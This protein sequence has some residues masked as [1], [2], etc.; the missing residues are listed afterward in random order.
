M[1]ELSKGADRDVPIGEEGETH[2]RANS[3]ILK[4]NSGKNPR[5]FKLCVGTTSAIPA[6]LQSYLPKKLTLLKTRPLSSSC[7]QN[8]VK[9][10]PNN[11][12]PTEAGSGTTA[13][14]RKKVSGYQR[15]GVD[16]RILSLVVHPIS[17]PVVRTPTADRRA[18]GSGSLDAPTSPPGQVPE[19]RE[20]G[21]GLWVRVGVR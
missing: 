5:R 17:K 18:G 20:G 8:S 11:R 9:V 10:N 19:S 7:T 14:S 1:G 16:I 13:P 12:A 6:V 3:G 15:R 2:Q 4:K 21:V